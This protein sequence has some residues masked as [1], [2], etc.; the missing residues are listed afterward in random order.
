MAGCSAIH[1]PPCAYREQM[2]IRLMTIAPGNVVKLTI[3]LKKSCHF[4]W[5]ADRIIRGLL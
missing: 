3:G 4:F 2:A 1:L 5:I